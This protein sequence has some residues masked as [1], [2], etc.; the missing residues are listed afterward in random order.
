M[1]YTNFMN[2]K[3]IFFILLMFFFKT[4]LQSQNYDEV[5]ISKNLKEIPLGEKIYIYEDKMNMYTLEE[6][7]KHL[8]EFRKSDEKILNFGYTTSSFWLYFKL[9]NVEKDRQKFLLSLSYPLLD[10]V[11]FYFISKN[12]ILKRIETGDMRNF[13]QREIQHRN[14]IFSLEL[15]P[16]E[17][18]EVYFKIESSGSIQIPLSI[19]SYESF[20]EK[21]LQE[22]YV[23][24][25]YYGIML[26]MILYNFFL[27][28]SIKDKS[29]LY[30]IL[31]IFGIMMFSLMFSGYAFQFFWPDFPRFSNLILP[32]MI[33]FLAFFA[34]LFSMY[35]LKIKE[36]TPILYKIFL[37]LNFIFILLMIVSFFLSYKVIIRIATYSIL[38]FVILA[39][40]SSIRCYFKGWKPARF[41]ILA[42]TMLLLGM[43][44]LALRQLGKLPVNLFTEYS[45]Q[46]GSV[47]E[48][49]LLSLG[50]ADRINVLKEEKEKAEKEILET[51]TIMLESFSRFV[52]KHFA[53]L[54]QKNSILEVKAGDSVEKKLT[55]LF[56]DIKNFTTLSEMMS[57]KET[58][59]FLNTY[60]EV[61]NPIILK[62]YGFI[63]KFIG[64]EIM[65]LF[66][67]EPDLSLISAIEMRKSIKEFNEKIKNL[68][69]PPVDMGI[70]INYG[71]MMLGT[72]GTQNRLDTTVIGDVVN[73]ASRV[74]QLT[75]LYA[76]SILL[77]E[78]VY[79][80][81]KQKDQFYLRKIPKVR[82]KGRIEVINVYECFN[83]DEEKKLEKKLMTL[84]KYEEAVYLLENKKYL[85]SY[86][87]FNEI[88]KLNTEDKVIEFYCKKLQKFIPGSDIQI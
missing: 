52:P 11:D 24:G 72:I 25:I 23:Q 15:E 29:Y 73:I 79:I 47:L 40:I 19:I 34:G 7:Q 67:R 64:D 43:F 39:F 50:L 13:S 18:Y 60:F 85:E 21:E 10:I 8:S 9:K 78:N 44:V 53:N 59:Q 35:F 68:N 80:N 33:G 42:W 77:T 41:Y 2:K 4:T 20:I 32:F 5:L 49:I 30:Y 12:K 84:N 74:Q 31:Y 36:L 6:I 87:L 65:A 54:L 45:L 55:V 56:N 63:D 81:L 27:F 58:F 26:V 22:Q 57:V 82:V 46:I 69:L 66:D 28:L 17:I 16:E 70:G 71:Q 3:S 48:V 14:F 62:Y 51:K 38:V 76:T 37:I 1:Y 83:G 61:M 88:Y 86:Q 75:R